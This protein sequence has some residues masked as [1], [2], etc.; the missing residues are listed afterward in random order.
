MGWSA[1]PPQAYTIGSR[2]G[3]ST[4][5]MHVVR[6][7]FGVSLLAA[8]RAGP[9]PCQS[10]ALATRVANDGQTYVRIPAGSFPM[11][12]AVEAARCPSNELPVHTVRISEPFW[13]GRTEV[14]T[15]AYKRFAL[16]T[17]RA[18]PVDSQGGIRPNANWAD[19]SL[20]ITLIS[21]ADAEAYCRWAGGGL[22]T[23]AQ[24]EL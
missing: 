7:A 10:I 11:G 21:F 3:G 13:L 14:T 4:G 17:H 15:A 6:I 23:E 22:P 12:C 18:M 9:I 2:L 5:E 1:W 24:W 19:D 8:L 16:A 20:P